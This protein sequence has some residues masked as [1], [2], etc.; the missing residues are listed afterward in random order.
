MMYLHTKFHLRGFNDSRVSAIKPK[1]EESVPHDHRVTLQSTN[2]MLLFLQ[3]LL[4]YVIL[5]LDKQS[6]QL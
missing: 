4:S 3:L 1:A 6:S 5:G 2:S